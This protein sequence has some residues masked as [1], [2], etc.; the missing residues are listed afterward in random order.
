MMYKSHVLLCGG[1]E[2]TK[3]GIAEI[4][5]Q[6]ERLLREKSIESDVKILKTDCFGLCEKGPIVVVYPEGTIYSEVTPDDIRKIVEEHLVNGRIV[7]ELTLGG[8][9]AKEALK[10]LE[11]VPFSSASLG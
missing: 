11:E 2:C 7:K 6:F 3:S 1:P 8:K 4:N 10:G 5:K 9:E